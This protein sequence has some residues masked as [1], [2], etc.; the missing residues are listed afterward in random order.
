MPTD[1]RMHP[2]E[3]PLAPQEYIHPSHA[4]THALFETLFRQLYLYFLLGLPALYFSRVT[5]IF[6][7]ADMSM[8]EIK[9]MALEM[10]AQ[11]KGPGKDQNLGFLTPSSFEPATV[12]PPYE[13]LKY[14][15]ESFIDSLMREWKTFNIISVLLLSYVCWF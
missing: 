12:P 2:P 15:W 11:A 3:D 1:P 4:D 7:E 6:K 5:M 8:P 9:K 13:N 10:P 14:T